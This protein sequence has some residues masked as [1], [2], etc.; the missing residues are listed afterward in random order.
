MSD[1]RHPG[2]PECQHAWALVDPNEED[3]RNGTTH[4]CVLAPGLHLT[5]RCVCGDTD[6]PVS[7]AISN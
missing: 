4:H 7:Q 2:D 3:R 5:H 6:T 1:E